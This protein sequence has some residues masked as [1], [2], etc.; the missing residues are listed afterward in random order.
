VVSDE[1]IQTYKTTIDQQGTQI[2]TLEEKVAELEASIQT[3]VKQN[4]LMVI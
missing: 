2:K 1:V 3:L 4:I